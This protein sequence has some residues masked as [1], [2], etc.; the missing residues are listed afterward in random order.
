MTMSYGSP[1]GATEADNRFTQLGLPPD[2]FYNLLLEADPRMTYFSTQDRFGRTPVQQE[3]FK[4]QFQPIFDQYL[5]QL[6]ASMRQGQFPTQT[7]SEFTEQFPFT[8]RFSSMPPSMRPGAGRRQFAPP[9]QF[10][11]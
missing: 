4:S 8:Q 11:F 6:G 7:F 5:G 3:Y 10:F 9:T 1:F 2:E